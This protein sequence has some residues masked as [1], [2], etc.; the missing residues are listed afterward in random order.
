MSPN[1]AKFSGEITKI[2]C[3]LVTQMST[4]EGTHQAQSPGTQAPV[5]AQEAPQAATPGNTQDPAA[6]PTAPAEPLPATPQ[7]P[8]ARPAGMAGHSPMG[9]PPPR[10]SS[11]G[12]SKANR[13]QVGNT[14]VH[15]YGAE[16]TEE[17]SSGPGGGEQTPIWETHWDSDPWAPKNK[18]GSEL[19]S[20]TRC[21]P[22]GK[23]S[24][25]KES[26]K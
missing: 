10:A 23:L 16:E 21:C 13:V 22:Q 12:R 14:T 18:H 24:P 6:A 17:V 4:S 25:Q 11:Q 19:A 9:R 20:A 7:A 15:V 3:N 2:Q 1:D 8:A 5:I 26:P